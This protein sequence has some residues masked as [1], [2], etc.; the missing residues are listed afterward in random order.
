[1][2]NFTVQDDNQTF[3]STA[4]NQIDGESVRIGANALANN[5][6]IAIGLNAGNALTTNE[7]C[8]GIGENAGQGAAGNYTIAI[9]EN[10]A[11]TNQQIASIAIGRNAG[12][13]DQGDAL[14]T[15]GYAIAIGNQAGQ[16]S[17]GN[18]SIAIGADAGR[19][20]SNT[21][22]IQIGDAAGQLN[23]GE[24][25]IAIGTRAGGVPDTSSIGQ[26]SIAIG[27]D[28]VCTHANAV[29]IGTGCTSTVNNTVHVGSVGVPFNIDATAPTNGAGGAT[30][31]NPTTYLR[32]SVNGT[33]YKIPLYV[34]T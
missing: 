16:T 20:N 6:N 12:N 15:S 23:A 22:S 24:D 11:V 5:Q 26:Q 33:L 21:R 17:Q 14:A 4:Q 27:S 30:P 9:G 3:I 1:M 13:T 32:I 28:T 31:A 25:S 10:A 34:N 2:S 7:G 8:V 18:V 29:V 19:L